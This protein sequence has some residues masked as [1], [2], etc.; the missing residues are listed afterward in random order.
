[1]PKERKYPHH[2]RDGAL[3]RA[4]VM[5]CAGYA[6]KMGDAAAKAHCDKHKQEMGI[7]E[8]AKTAQERLQWERYENAIEPLFV[9]EQALVELSQEDDS[10]NARI[11]GFIEEALNKEFNRSKMGEFMRMFGPRLVQME[12]KIENLEQC[13]AE[14]QPGAKL[15]SETAPDM[16]HIVTGVIE[17]LTARAQQIANSPVRAEQLQGLMGRNVAVAY[18]KTVRRNA[19]RDLGFSVK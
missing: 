2:K 13:A 18:A 12:M 3:D 17:G 5:A 11:G 9:I 8:F 19:L 7:G 6:A 4:H 1:M 10:L 16:T 14:M 15:A